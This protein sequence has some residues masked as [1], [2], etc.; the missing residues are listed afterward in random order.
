MLTI[1]P[2]PPVF[3]VCQSLIISSF[4]HYF[5]P[6]QPDSALGAWLLTLWWVINTCQGALASR[7]HV[8][9]VLQCTYFDFC[10]FNC[11]WLYVFSEHQHLQVFNFAGVRVVNCKLNILL[12]ISY[13]VDQYIYGHLFVRILRMNRLIHFLKPEN[14]LSLLKSFNRL[15]TNM[16][17][18]SEYL[19]SI[20]KWLY[21]YMSNI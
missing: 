21:T 20:L 13:I 19:F 4:E 2:K 8:Q 9:K 16:L 18:F 7:G 14:N 1:G 12:N 11:E 15:T 3:E 10:G 6:F 5:V 17:L